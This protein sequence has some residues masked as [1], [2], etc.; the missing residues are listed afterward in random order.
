[1]SNPETLADLVRGGH[2]S[3]GE[4]REI[5]KDIFDGK[6][7]GAGPE[8]Y[9]VTFPLF[10]D[11]PDH[12]QSFILKA[13]QFSKVENVLDYQSRIDEQA[14]DLALSEASV[15]DVGE[16]LDAEEAEYSDEGLDNVARSIV[17]TGPTQKPE[18]K[19]D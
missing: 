4:V 18:P 17:G 9:V 16:A 13:F 3:L 1:M 12:V 7:S 6:T 8:G 11:L 5:A 19:E 14:E 15:A 10:D 2:A